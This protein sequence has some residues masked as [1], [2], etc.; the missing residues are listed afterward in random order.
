[1]SI[2]RQEPGYIRVTTGNLDL[3]VEVRDVQVRY[4]DCLAFAAVDQVVIASSHL[5]LVN[6]ACGWPH[7]RYRVRSGPDGPTWNCLMCYCRRTSLRGSHT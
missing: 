5:R 1:M 7:A 4:A 2:G 6:A 3:P